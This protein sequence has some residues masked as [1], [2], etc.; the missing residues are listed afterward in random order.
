MAYQIWWFWDKLTTL[1]NQM[2][3][4]ILPQKVVLLAD[5]KFQILFELGKV[6]FFCSTPAA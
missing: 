2:A 6:N 5:K 1:E 3:L 4:I